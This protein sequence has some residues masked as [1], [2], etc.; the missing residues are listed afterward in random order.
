MKAEGLA[1]PSPAL[2][3]ALTLALTV[4]L[5]RTLALALVLTLILPR[6]GHEG[7]ICMPASWRPS[8]GTSDPAFAIDE[9]VA[10]AGVDRMP[11]PP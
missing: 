4:T 11:I 1:S 2:T 3:L 9:I 7:T 10:L 5:A 8:R 6:H